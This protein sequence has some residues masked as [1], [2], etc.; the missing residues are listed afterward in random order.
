MQVIGLKAQLDMNGMRGELIALDKTKG[1]WQVGLADGSTKMIKPEN[2]LKAAAEQAAD[3]DGGESALDDYA[4]IF[5]WDGPYDLDTAWARYE[6]F[7]PIAD[8]DIIETGEFGW[9]DIRITFVR[10]IQQA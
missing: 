10:V 6:Q 8:F 2:L 5:P 9:P 7:G 4:I 3:D 1:R